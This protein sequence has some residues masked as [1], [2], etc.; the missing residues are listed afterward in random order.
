MTWSY[1][2]TTKTL[3]HYGEV[4]YDKDSLAQ[5]ISTLIYVGLVREATTGGA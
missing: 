5:L 2:P 3:S 1:N 4:V